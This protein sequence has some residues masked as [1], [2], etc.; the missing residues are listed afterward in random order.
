MMRDAGPKLVIFDCDGTLVDSGAVI[1]ACMTRAFAGA[2]LEPPTLAAPHGVIGLSLDYAIARLLA[3][4]PDMLVGELTEAYKRHF[5]TI[6][7]EPDFSEPL[8][9]GIAALIDGLAARDD[10]VLGMVTG[11]S[12]RGVQAVFATHG[13]GPRF[14]VVRTADDCPSKPHPAMV[15]ECCAEAGFDPASTTVVGDA[16]YDFVMARSAGARAVGVGWGYHDRT[17]LEAAG[18]YAVLSRPS[19]LLPMLGL[20]EIA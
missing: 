9:D 5:L 11:K 17:A 12:R 6:R 10:I 15:L 2:G 13:F 14:M 3:R 20:A 8:Y 16:I 4:E 19:D 7:S 1:H 18:A